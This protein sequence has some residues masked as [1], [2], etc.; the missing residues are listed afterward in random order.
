MP[1]KDRPSPG[2]RAAPQ[3]SRKKRRAIRE[4]LE[5]LLRLEMPP[6]DKEAAALLGVP[7]KDMN[8]AMRLALSLFRKAAAGDLSALKEIRAI[9]EDE[10]SGGNVVIH[11]V[12]DLK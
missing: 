2:A 6:E 8:N 3:R 5:L 9:T 4:Y 11:I 12:D 1:S 10:F 7:E